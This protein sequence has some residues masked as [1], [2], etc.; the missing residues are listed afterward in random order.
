MYSI[1]QDQ[2]DNGAVIRVAADGGQRPDTVIRGFSPRYA[3]SRDGKVVMLLIKDVTSTSDRT[4]GLT[5]ALWASV[6]G[7]P[8]V[9]LARPANGYAQALSPDHH[10]L[11]YDPQVDR[12]EVFV[13]PFPATGQRTQ[14]S[15]EGGFE[16]IFSA[17]GDQL[18]F[19]NGRRIMVSSFTP[20]DPPV[21]GKPVEFVAAD[22]ADFEG[23][24]WKLAPDGRFLVKLLPSSAPRSKIRVMIGALNATRGSP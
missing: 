14:V 17:R 8:F 15:T 5:S 18:F 1:A 24:A 4:T 9:R 7:K 2:N 19:R 23:R 16:P 12:E 21:V 11:T 22:F 6:E 10:F 20:G 3:V 13:E